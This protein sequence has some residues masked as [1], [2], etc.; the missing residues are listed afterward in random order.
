MS[1][2]LETLYNNSPEQKC[3]YC[4]KVTKY[5]G[6]DNLCNRQC[7][8]GLSNLLYDYE[9]GNVL[10][11]DPRIVEYFTKYRVPTHSFIFDK[12]KEYL[13]IIVI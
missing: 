7:Y 8:Y 4:S 10:E 9:K 11:P 13:S 1:N 5:R 6:W 12:L 2:I 3:Y